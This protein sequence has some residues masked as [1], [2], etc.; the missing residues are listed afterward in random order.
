MRIGLVFKTLFYFCSFFVVIASSSLLA[1][2][3]YTLPDGSVLQDPTKPQLWGAPR[4]SGQQQ[5]EPSFKLNYI[6]ASG[7][8]KRAM[9][10][11]HKVVV[12]DVVAGAT[13]KQISS[14]SVYLIYKGKQ[15]VLSMNKV[16]GITRN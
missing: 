11:G 14:D 9:I 1:E 16:K 12:G 4:A 10:N 8:D 13:V 15:K 5:R 3:T 6:V 2:A 7:Q